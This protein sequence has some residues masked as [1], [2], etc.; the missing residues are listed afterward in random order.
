MLEIHRYENQ[1]QWFM[2][3]NLYIDPLTP[4]GHSLV[5]V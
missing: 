2:L 4:G 1:I 5:N 3:M